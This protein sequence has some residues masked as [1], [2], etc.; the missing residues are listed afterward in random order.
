MQVTLTDVLVQ[1]RTKN[2]QKNSGVSKQYRRETNIKK[3]WKE[4]FS[5]AARERFMIPA[6]T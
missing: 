3:W 4:M 6:A 2:V 1:R 5:L